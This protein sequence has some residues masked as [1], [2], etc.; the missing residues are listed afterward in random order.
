MAD[1][2]I[3]GFIR[4]Q[5]G[6]GGYD[7]ATD[8]E[9]IE[10][11][12]SHR[13]EVAFEVLIRRHDRLVRSA[14]ARVIAHPDDADDAVQATFLVLVRRARR[15]D[16]RAELGPWLYGVAHRVAVKLR[17]GQRGG[18]QPLGVA[19]PTAPAANSDPSWREA[20]DLLHAE[21]DRLPDRY[22]LPLLLCY[23]EG[24]T[25]DQA[26][27][28]LGVS[29]G[30]LKGRVRHGCELLRRRLARRGVSLSIGLLG[31]ATANPVGASDVPALVASLS[32]PPSLR[33]AALVQEVTRTMLI[34]KWKWL[35]LVLVAVAGPVVGLALGD[36]P[37]EPVRGPVPTLPAPWALAPVLAPVPKVTRPSEFLVE[38][39]SDPGHC[40]LCYLG[41]DGSAKDRS[42]P[43]ALCAA[44]SPDGRWQAACEHDHMRQ[45]GDLVIRPRGWAAE[46]VTVP[47]LGGQIGSSIL[48]VWSPDSKRVF[49]GE[50]YFSNGTKREFGYRVYDLAEK[51]MTQAKV[52][53]RC[54][55]TDWSLDGKRFLANFSD[56]DSNPR[57]AWLTVDGT[58]KPEFVTPDGEWASGG[59]LSPDGRRVLYQ[60]GPKPPKGERIKVRLY[61]MDLTTKKQ[62][63]VDEPGE[64]HGHCWSP[65]GTRVAYTWQKTLDKPEETPER[66]TL[67]ITCDPDGRDRK[68]LTRRKTTLSPDSSGRGGV[69]CFFWVRDWR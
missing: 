24:Q 44:L 54:H 59:R 5:L 27:R 68:T 47:L 48:P 4:R 21:L 34:T 35:V 53:D 9:L 41:S 16:W 14:V 37:T 61:V 1:R 12:V 23:L 22:R 36:R 66:E 43:P 28:T 33:V 25:R 31:A 63:A 55:V 2:G 45:K 29:V 38:D 3:V 32:G 6:P 8:R 26:A 51:T 67:L 56:S 18:L 40:G 65:D 20:R 13:D 50:E 64:T 39:A 52:P 42:G 11:F 62:T 49:I 58:G 17:S 15:S 7:Q 30:A 60:S 69:V 10:W 57:I 19:E 46:P